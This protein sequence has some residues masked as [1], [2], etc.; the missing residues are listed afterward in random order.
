MAWLVMFQSVGRTDGTCQGTYSLASG[1]TH[2]KCVYKGVVGYPSLIIRNDELFVAS[3]SNHQTIQNEQEPW[4][5]VCFFEL[6]FSGLPRGRVLCT[7]VGALGITS[8]SFPQSSVADVF[9]Y[10]CSTSSLTDLH[11]HPA[12]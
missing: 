11:L 3:L 8:Q 1:S 10:P 7:F 5:D 9:V 6:Y 2:L 4:G 12:R